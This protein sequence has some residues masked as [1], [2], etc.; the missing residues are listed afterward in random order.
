MYENIELRQVFANE[1][2]KLMEK[3]ERI[4]LIDADL[5]RANGTLLLHEKYKDRAFEAGIA[6][7]NMTAVAAGMAAYGFIPFIGSFTAF[8]TRRCCDQIAISIA[9]AKRNVKIVGSDP[10][11]SAEYNGGTHMSMEDIGVL[12]S[13][14]GMII[15]EPVDS[16]QLAAAMPEIAAY[17]GAIYI[18]LFRKVPE[19][20]FGEGY[21]F[22]LFKA[23]V[24]D[25]GSDVSLF[26]SGIMVSEAIKA[27]QIL[28]KDG[29]SS[30]VINIHT[31]KPA[32]REAILKSVKK[33]G[34]A[35]TCEN[36]NIIGGLYSAVTEV[37]ADE[38]PIPVKA[39]GVNDSFGKVG[40]MNY[41]KGLFNM[42][43]SDIVE[44]AKKVITLKK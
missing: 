3:D 14:P 13:I 27:A 33:T 31:I 41:L 36:H 12:R 29:I 20:V 37:L 24:I 11:I 4:V 44:V 16:I 6:E 32:D 19:P 30:E 2:E 34:C 10:G 26:A 17:D 8:A 40:K 21:K 7:Q 43:V 1:L 39:I 15:F 18:R 5:A 38:F 35:V 25:E 42:N 28:K 9:Y 23:D 22:S